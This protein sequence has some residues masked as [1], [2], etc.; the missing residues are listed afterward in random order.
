MESSIRTRNVL[1]EN[2]L[3]LYFLKTKINLISLFTINVSER[4]R[5]RRKLFIMVCR[6]G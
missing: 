1:A 4:K 6:G 2:V 3:R 5:P